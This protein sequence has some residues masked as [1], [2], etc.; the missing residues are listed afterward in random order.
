MK[1]V[2]AKSLGNDIKIQMSEIFVDGFYQWLQ[3]FSKD[4]NKLVKA[5][6]HIFNL[7]VFYFAVI[8][9]EIAGIIACTDEK[10]PSVRL[11]RKEFR[12]HLG[13]IRGIIT[14][15]MLKR[16]FED[17]KYPFEISEG[18]GMVEFVATSPIN[19]GKGVATA[20]MN[21]IILSTVYDEYVLEV[22]DTNT[23]AIKLYEKLGFKEFLRIKQKHS[24]RSGVNHLVYMK[25]CK[26][27]WK[28]IQ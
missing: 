14:Y 27:K 8:D 6:S 1:I 4:K 10:M 9:G 7:D 13:I 3:F 15:F 20:I 22:A 17:K 26:T 25:F 16:E 2:G 28:D 18:M 21:E 12:K 24:E 23:A 5:F 11:N 19:R